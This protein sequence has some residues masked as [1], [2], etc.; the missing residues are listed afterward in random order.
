MVRLLKIISLF[1]L[2]ISLQAQRPALQKG[3]LDTTALTPTDYPT[4]YFE[5]GSWVGG[6]TSHTLTPVTTSY[7]TNTLFVGVYYESAALATISSVVWDTGGANIAL[8][9]VTNVGSAASGY[10]AVYC[11]TNIALASNKDIVATFSDTTEVSIVNYVL[12]TDVNQTTP[13]SD[14]QVWSDTGA[15]A[16]NTTV[17]TPSD[18]LAYGFIVASDITLSIAPPIIK[19]SSFNN[20]SGFPEGTSAYGIRSGA[21]TDLNWTHSGTADLLSVTFA[22]IAD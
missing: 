10:L 7:A 15:S 12:V 3:M 9:L 19:N 4:L 18:S 8:G 20:G 1:G 21:T 16:L 13:Y 2:A 11:A 17:T 6:G 14:E 22:I 5:S